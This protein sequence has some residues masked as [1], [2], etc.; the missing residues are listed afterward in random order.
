MSACL[1]EVAERGVADQN[2]LRLGL[3]GGPQDFGEARRAA[4][5]A[6]HQHRVAGR[7]RGQFLGDGLAGSRQQ[8][9][10]GLHL[11]QQFA[12][13]KRQRMAVAEADDPDPLAFA[14]I[15]DGAAGQ[16]GGNSLQRLGQA[17]DIVIEMAPE[18]AFFRARARQSRPTASRLRAPARACWRISW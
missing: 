17:G 3:G 16:V 10:V 1:V 2:D 7:K 12:R 14:R 6:E 5:K 4:A 11:R 15:V 8:P 13:I 9:H 18:R